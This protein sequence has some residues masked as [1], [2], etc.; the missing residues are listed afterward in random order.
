[1]AAVETPIACCAP[2][3]APVLDEQEARGV[4]KLGSRFAVVSSC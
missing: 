2:L 4:Q 1:M 3:A